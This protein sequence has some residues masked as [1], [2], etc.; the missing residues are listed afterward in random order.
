MSMYKFFHK[1]ASECADYHKLADTM[2]FP[3]RFSLIRWVENNVVADR[4]IQ[5]CDGIIKLIKVQG[6]TTTSHLKT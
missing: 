3:H 6:Q 5:I 1:A 4:G 2:L